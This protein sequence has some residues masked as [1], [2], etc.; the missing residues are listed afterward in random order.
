MT[1]VG[2][3]GFTSAANAYTGIYWWLR[4][5]AADGIPKTYPHS[6]VTGWEGRRS[7][8]W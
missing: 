2:V 8:K 3:K 1:T 5:W 4:G 6:R 7:E